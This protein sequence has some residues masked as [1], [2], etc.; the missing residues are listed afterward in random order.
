MFDSESCVR[1]FKF[2][3]LLGSSPPR[4]LR[5]RL[6]A[7]N[8][9]QKERP[10]GIGPRNRLLPRPRETRF[11]IAEQL[12]LIGPLRE[13]LFKINIRSDGEFTKVVGK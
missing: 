7:F 12:R 4:L 3:K 1:D 13:F 8:P 5:A 11:F 9:L 2:L 6:S 10:S